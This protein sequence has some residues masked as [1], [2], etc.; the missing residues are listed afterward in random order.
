MAYLHDIEQP[1]VVNYSFDAFVHDSSF[2]DS[3]VDDVLVLGHFSGS[4]RWKYLEYSF[5]KR[6]TDRAVMG[7]V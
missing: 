2:Q 3:H 4:M 7:R 6:L 1:E 5:E